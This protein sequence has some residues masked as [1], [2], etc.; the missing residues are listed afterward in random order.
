MTAVGIPSTPQAGVQAKT[1]RFNAPGWQSWIL[2][3]VLVLATVAVYY[4]AASHPFANYDDDAYVTRNSAIQSGLNWQ[5]AQWAFTTYYEANWHP[6]TWLSHALDCQLFELDPAGHHE[7]NLLLHCCNVLLLFWVLWRATGYPGRSLMVAALFAL[8]P[9]NVESVA[10]VA[11]RKNVLSMFFFLLAL[12]AYGWYA[13]K[14]RAGRMGIVIL[15]YALALM[16]K[17]QVITFPCV[18]VLWD[19]WPLRRMLAPDATSSSGTHNVQP[20]PA[21]SIRQLLW[22]KVPLLALSAASAILTM[23]AQFGGNAE[24][25][26]PKYIRLGNAVLAYGKYIAKAVWPSPLTLLYPHP[27]YSLS[28]WQVGASLLFLLAVTAYVAQ[29]WRSQRYLPVGWLWFLGTLVP[30]IGLVQVGVQAMADRYAYLPFIGLFIM[31]CWWAADWSEERRIPQRLVVGASLV[32]LLA[33]AVV[34]R[35]Q[36]NYWHDNQGLWAHALEVTT[37][38]HVAEDN[39]GGSLLD[40]GEMEQAIPH[41]YRALAIW[42]GDT[43]AALNVGFYEAKHGNYATALEYYQKVVSRTTKPSLRAKAYMNMG[44][45]YRELHDYSQSRDNLKMAVELDPKNGEA[46]TFLG[47]AAQRC[48]DFDLAVQAYRQGMRLRPTAWGYLLLSQAL[49]QSGNPDEARV[50]RRKAEG[51]SLDFDKTQQDAASALSH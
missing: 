46:W 41:F 39:Y 50:T 10:W 47:V 14:P 25:Y 9:I 16:A 22:E 15:L 45:A 3:A 34:A 6:V 27:G 24:T 51:M 21:R 43:T 31:I 7:M 35:H 28:W 20:S 40:L 12:G 37:D 13:R 1:A 49:E 33:L 18:L 4:P 5:T 17:P 48:G 26:F 30:M 11:E 32:V 42:P 29:H 8:H 23:Q 44:Y 19:Y 36:L 2:L 38:N